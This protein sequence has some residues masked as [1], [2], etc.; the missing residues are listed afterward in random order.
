MKSPG[1]VAR[2]FAGDLDI[3]VIERRRLHVACIGEM[4]FIEKVGRIISKTLT[5]KDNIKWILNKN[6]VEWIHQVHD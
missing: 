6:G 5:W 2:V 3:K 4:S 1:H